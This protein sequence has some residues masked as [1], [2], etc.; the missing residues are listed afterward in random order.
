MVIKF[1]RDQY[2]QI[3]V[4]NTNARKLITA[5]F[6]FG[7]F[8][9]FYLIFANTFIF[10]ATHGN[11]TLNLLYCSFSFLGITLGFVINGYLLRYIHVKKQMISGAFMLFLAIVIMFLSPS[12]YINAWSLLSCT[13]Y[14]MP[15][16]KHKFF[17]AFKLPSPSLLL[18]AF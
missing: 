2:S 9:P 16:F 10:S 11:I 3:R 1:I 14:I 6:L 12:K 13:V 15:M 7:L 5:N 18:I 17:T 4:F 8:N